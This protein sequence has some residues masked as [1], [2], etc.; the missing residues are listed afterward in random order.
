[1]PTNHLQA[2]IGGLLADY[3]TIAELIAGQ[4]KFLPE[5]FAGLDADKAR[6]KYSCLKV[7]RLVSETHPAVLYPEFERIVRLLEVENAPIKWGAIVIIGNL[8]AVDAEKKID[9][10]LDRYLRPVSE[11]DLITAGNVV[12]GAAKIAQARPELADRIAGALLQIE[13]AQ[14]QT[15]EC[16]N[17]ALGHA[18]QSL[19]LFFGHIRDAKPVIAF[20]ERQLGN[21]RDAVRHKA[22]VFLKRHGRT[23][24]AAPAD[25]SRQRRRK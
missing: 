11:H 13:K 25:E 16:R 5:V 8:A 10:I 19:G 9:G 21:R 17:V 1:M 24:P 15:A 3:R 2:K 18:V 7:I 14:Y 20:V 12:N 4:P 23:P 6:I 22:A